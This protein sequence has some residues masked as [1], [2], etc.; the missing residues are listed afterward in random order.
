MK[1]SEDL[2]LLETHRWNEIVGAQTGN[3]QQ[4]STVWTRKT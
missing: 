1:T 2:L 4:F 3:Y